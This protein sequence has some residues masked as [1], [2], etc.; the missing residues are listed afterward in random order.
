MK[1]TPYQEAVGSLMFAAQLSRLDIGNIVLSYI[2]TDKMVADF[3]TKAVTKKEDQ[4]HKFKIEFFFDTTKIR[5]KR[6]NTSETWVG[7]V[8]AKINDGAEMDVDLEIPH[9]RYFVIHHIDL[10]QAA[11]AKLE[12]QLSIAATRSW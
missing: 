11:E 4:G 1:D 8:T 9:K 3:L 12:F 10:G 2:S 7:N 5:R 6:A